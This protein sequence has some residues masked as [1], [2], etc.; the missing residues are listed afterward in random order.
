MRTHNNYDFPTIFDELQ[1][2]A[3]MV[4]ASNRGREITVGDLQYVT[5]QTMYS[6]A[7]TGALAAAPVINPGTSLN[8]FQTGQDEQGQGWNGS[9]TE[10]ETNFRGSNGQFPANQC[11][12]ATRAAWSVWSLSA[13]DT[14]GVGNTYALV[15]EA[16]DLKALIGKGVWDLSI[17]RGPTREIGNLSDYPAASGVYAGLASQ[18]A[19]ATDPVSA[20]TAC[21]NGWPSE[22]MKPLDVPIV[23][24]PLVNVS[25]GATWHSGFTLATTAAGGNLGATHIAVRLALFGFQFTMPV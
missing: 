22:P 20:S 9:L 2:Y 17:G 21:Q 6:T 24:P 15:K 5:H 3:N 8:F 18:Q 1:P 19:G 16:D 14:G 10:S 23:F 4:V 7:V 12:V 25:I 11:F 13:A